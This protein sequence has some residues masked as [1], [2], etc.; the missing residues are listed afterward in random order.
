MS[1]TDQSSQVAYY[2]ILIG[3]DT[4]QEKPLQGSVRDVQNVK[5]FLEGLPVPVQIH[6]LASTKSE[7]PASSTPWPTYQNVTSA[8]EQVTFKAN[9]GDYVYIHFSGHGTRGAPQS[10]FSNLSTGD[11]ALV[12]LDQM[13]QHKVRYLWGPTLAI[14]L[15]AMVDKGLVVSLVLDCCFSAS[16]FR[17]KDPAVRFLPFDGSIDDKIVTDLTIDPGEGST[18]PAAS[19]A[20]DASML[21]NWLINP[22]G[23]AIITACGPN[24][25]AREIEGP[26]KQ[27]RGALSQ[28]LLE[29]MEH[30]SV[31][32]SHGELFNQLCAKF[33]LFNVRQHPVFY[34]NKLQ[35]FFQHP[36]LRSD[37]VHLR[38]VSDE[39]CGVQLE[40]G[41]AH[42]VCTGDRFLLSPLRSSV[43]GEIP[44][45]A[46]IAR[47]G[48]LTSDL[49]MIDNTTL[50][51]TDRMAWTAKP[52]TKLLLQRYAVRLDSSI[53]RREEWVQFLKDR[54][55][56]VAS[57]TSQT[58][59][60]LSLSSAEEYQICNKIGQR[61]VNLPSMRQD[62]IGLDQVCEII[63]HL[64]N[65]EMSFSVHIISGERVYAEFDSIE[66]NHE[67]RVHLRVENKGNRDLYVF[68]YYLGSRW[69]VENILR[70]TYKVVPPPSRDLGFTGLLMMKIA[71][72]VPAEVVGKEHGYCEDIIKVFVTSRATSFDMIELPKLGTTRVVA[73]DLKIERG[74]SGKETED[75]TASDFS[76][77]TNLKSILA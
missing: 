50:I 43:I 45:R 16:V 8:L 68:V 67:D 4:Y 53:S 25:E 10:Q 32:E 74:R 11:L 77:R 69:Q 12:L 73:K 28:L 24:E 20:R 46:V 38:A 34:G 41:Q 15:K 63:Q 30:T 76:I 26:D 7:D 66:V 59:F 3:I 57:E 47:A 71:M 21:P 35:R 6:L 54:S 5:Q 39:V 14:A 36:C 27:I 29:V 37:G 48:D 33:Q 18:Q 23:Y 72:K 44:R 52:H 56:L 42:G 60:Y 19:A 58:A 22:D 40:A 17:R 49:D 62:Q 75:W 70:G 31:Q 2:A 9:A 1:V 64:A 51:A 61:I 65:F 13:P 55:L